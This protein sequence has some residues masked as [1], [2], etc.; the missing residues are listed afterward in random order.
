MGGLEALAAAQTASPDLILLDI[1]MPGMDG[2]EVCRQLKA[3]ERTARIPVIF[4]SAQGDTEDKVQAFRLGGVDY[5]T[6]PFHV[7]EVLARVETHLTL[8]ETQYQL[9]A[10]NRQLEKHIEDLARSNQELDMLWNVSE[11]LNQCV[12]LNDT[13]QAGL[14]AISV[15]IGAQSGWLILLE[16]SGQGRLAAAYHL[17][18]P[19]EMACG[20]ERILPAVRK[21]GP[22]AGG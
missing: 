16:K 22:A 11:V 8:Q 14:K 3:D 5:I 1:N 7:E 12:T 15:E 18:K 21:P 4:V 10:T 19:V 9:Q 13:F 20:V 2:Y 6:R 17:A